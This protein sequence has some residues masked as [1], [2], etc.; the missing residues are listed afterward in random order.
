MSWSV[1]LD[2]NLRRDPSLPGAF[3][4]VSVR[5]RPYRIRAGTAQRL[6]T[7][8]AEVTAEPMPFECEH[9]VCSGLGRLI[10]MET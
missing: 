5:D 2:T 8:V 7:D 4:M 10:S 6:S 3:A 9:I 1:L